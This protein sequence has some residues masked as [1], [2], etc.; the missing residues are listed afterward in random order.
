MTQRAFA[1][2][3]SAVDSIRSRLR[4]VSVGVLT[5]FDDGLEIAHGKMEANAQTLYDAGA[6]SFLAAANISEYHSLS[7]S[8]R[9]DVTESCVDALP[10]DACVLAGIDGST[11][12]ATELIREYDHVGVD[13]MMVMP[14]DHTYVHER[15]LLDY[16]RKLATATETPLVPYVRGF[17]PS[18]KFLTDL[19]RID[20]VAGVKYAVK[21]AVTLGAAVAAGDDG[22]VWVDGLAEPHSVAFWAESVEGFT[23]GVSNFRP[24]VG[25]ELFNAL[26]AGNWE[27][28]RA[29]R[30]ICLPYQ[31]LRQGTGDN[32]S[33]PG[34][35]SVPVVK[36][37]LELAGLHDGRVRGAPPAAVT[38][39]RE[40]GDGALRATRRRRRT[41]RRLIRVPHPGCRVLLRHD[42][43]GRR[44]GQK[45][46]ATERRREAPVATCANSR[47][48][49]VRPA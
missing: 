15:G 36:K 45:S 44:Y 39:R 49:S 32:N 17:D 26:S 46:D 23:A 19:T 41:H 13:A 28:A 43:C 14:P 16:Y 29:L 20:G 38:G 9:R 8:E 7:Q 37:G 40:A 6:R 30:D 24:E 35:I 31:N 10:S 18:V 12:D 47:P 34:A 48:R 2:M 25:F 22:V 21:D 3:S 33:V 11:P 5:P 4:G 42:V 27:R 1:R